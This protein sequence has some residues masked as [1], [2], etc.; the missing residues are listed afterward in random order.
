[1]NT[2]ATTASRKEDIEIEQRAFEVIHAAGWS[3]VD[4]IEWMLTYVANEGRLPFDI[5]AP[6]ATQLQPE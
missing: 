1:M 6:K 2:T 5:Q 3:V 4:V